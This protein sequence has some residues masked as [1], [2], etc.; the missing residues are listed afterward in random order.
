M[1]SEKTT[2]VSKLFSEALIS[3]FMV[4]DDL[5]KGLIF[6]VGAVF[7]AIFTAVLF[8]KATLMSQGE[9]NTTEVEEKAAVKE[10]SGTATGVAKGSKEEQEL[11]AHLLSRKVVP[12]RSSAD[13]EEE[14][15]ISVMEED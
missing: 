12:I 11:H 10:S 8:I 6:G 3:R 13:Y 9:P 5:V 14:M 15:E 2:S 7:L 4:L 1:S